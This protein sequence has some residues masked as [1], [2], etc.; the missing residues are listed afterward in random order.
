MCNTDAACVPQPGDSPLAVYGRDGKGGGGVAARRDATERPVPT[1]GST[2]TCGS[3]AHAWEGRPTPTPPAGPSRHDTVRSAQARAPTVRSAPSRSRRGYWWHRP[4]RATV[5][6]GGI[7]DTVRR[8]PRS[9]RGALVTPSDACHG[10]G[11]G[12]SKIS[13]SKKE[14]PAPRNSAGVRKRLLLLEN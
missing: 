8:V 7:G 10:R 1:F 3:T 5:E 2:V 6:E 14:A 11:G 12:A 9:R 4:T 13:R